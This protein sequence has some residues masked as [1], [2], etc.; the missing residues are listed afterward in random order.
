MS[1]EETWSGELSINVAGLK[2][3]GLGKIHLI[4]LQE[5]D[6]KTCRVCPDCG[7]IP[8]RISHGADY[9]C[10]KCKKDFNT[11]HSLK[12]ALPIDKTKDNQILERNY[13]RYRFQS[14]FWKT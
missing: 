1:S 3:V 11:W 13:D 8:E 7:S 5:K 6:I 14:S 12:Q 10:E 4:K 9:H 2:S